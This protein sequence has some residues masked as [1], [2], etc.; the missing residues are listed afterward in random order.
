MQSAEP[1]H[2]P[3]QD[4][5][6]ENVANLLSVGLHLGYSDF[7]FIYDSKWLNLTPE[8]PYMNHPTIL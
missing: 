1:I 7:R 5:N 8:A 4:K 2:Y 6:K 3:Q